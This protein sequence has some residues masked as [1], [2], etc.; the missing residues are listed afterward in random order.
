M[1]GTDVTRPAT[2]STSIE[3]PI[4]A[5]P[6]VTCAP[7]L[8]H[9]IIKK[10]IKKRSISSASQQRCRRRQSDVA[11]HRS[12]RAKSARNKRRRSQTKTKFNGATLIHGETFFKTTKTLEKKTNQRQSNKT[13]L[14]HRLRATSFALMGVSYVNDFSF[15]FFFVFLFLRGFSSR[16]RFSLCVSISVIRIGRWLSLTWSR[17]TSSHLSTT[18]HSSLPS[19]LPGFARSDFAGFAGFSQKFPRVFMDFGELVWVLRVFFQGCTVRYGFEWV[20]MGIGE[21]F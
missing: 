20:L 1:G 5:G 14:R 3:R 9:E 15:F 19:F 10:I 2:I 12:G 6:P 4:A 11:G 17:W 13:V 7:R 18:N 8:R 21:M 16:S